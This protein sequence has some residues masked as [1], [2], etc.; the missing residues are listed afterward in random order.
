[1]SFPRIFRQFDAQLSHAVLPRKGCLPRGAGVLPNS[2]QR[3]FFR[4]K[5]ARPDLMKWR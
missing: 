5:M 3:L 1:M 4:G 2:L